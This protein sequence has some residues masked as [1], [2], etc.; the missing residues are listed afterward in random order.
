MQQQLRRC[1]MCDIAQVGT[2]SRECKNRRDREYKYHMY[3][4]LSTS[5]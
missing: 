5:E 2:L 3:A 4:F 1:V